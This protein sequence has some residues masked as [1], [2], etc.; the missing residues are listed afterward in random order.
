MNYVKPKIFDITKRRPAVLLVGNGL[1]R[2]MGDDTTWDN[3]I[4]KLA[5]D[6]AIL[7]KIKRLDYSIRAT[8]TADEDDSKR[9]QRYVK[10]FDN[11]FK[12]FDN[13]LL[14]N[15]LR[16][17][18]DAVLTTNYTYELENALDENFPRSD[19]KEDWACT[20]AANFNTRKQPDSVRLLNTFNRLKNEDGKDVD[21]WHIHGEVRDPASMILTH[22]EYGRLVTE[23]VREEENENNEGE[24][25]FNS[26]QDYFVYGD[27]YILGQGVNFAEFDLW[28]M[29]SRRRREKTGHGRTI[30]YAPQQFNKRFTDVEEALDQIGVKIDNCGVTLPEWGTK[31]QNEMNQIFRNF[32]NTASDRIRNKI[33]NPLPSDTELLIE[34]REK[35]AKNWTK[36][37]CIRMM[38]QLAKTKVFTPGDIDENELFVPWLYGYEGEDLSILALFTTEDAFPDGKENLIELTGLE[39]LELAEEIPEIKSINIDLFSPFGNVWLSVKQAEYMRKN[40]EELIKYVE[41]ADERELQ[42]RRNN[43]LKASEATHYV[44]SYI[45]N[46]SFDNSLDEL[47]FDIQHSGYFNY[48]ALYHEEEVQWTAPKWAKP[49]DIAFF[50]HT[51]T[52]KSIITRLRTELK[53]QKDTMPTEKYTILDREINRALQNYEKIGGKIFAIGQVCAPTEEIDEDDPF[54]SNDENSKHWLSRSYACVSNIFLLKHPV[55][56]DDF[57]DFIMLARGGSYSVV[58]GE[59]FSRLRDLIMEK[60]QD[61]E[62]FPYY[63]RKSVAAPLALSDITDNNWMQINSEMRS[64][65][66]GKTQFQSFYTN[67]LLRSIGDTKKYWQRCRFSKPEMANDAIMDSVIV[68]NKKYLP[69]RI[70]FNPSD[71]GTPAEIAGKYCNAAEIFI[72]KDEKIDISRIY[73]DRVMVIDRENISIYDA[74]SEDLHVLMQLDDLKS[75]EDVAVLKQKLKSALGLSGTP[76]DSNETTSRTEPDMQLDSV[77]EPADTVEPTL[78]VAP[79]DDDETTPEN[80]DASQVSDYQGTLYTSAE[81]PTTSLGWQEY[82]L[83]AN[84]GEI[85]K[86]AHLIVQG[87]KVIE[88]EK[89]IEKLRLSF[90]VR[91]SE[92][93]TDA[94]EKAI[95]AAK[96]QISKIKGVVYCWAAE[97]DPKTYTGFRYHEDVK[98]RDDELPLT[99]IRN[100]VV[101]TLL[102][103]GPLGEDDLLVQTCRTFGYQRLGPNL[104]KRLSEGIDF[105][106]AD[107]KI[108]LNKQKQYELREW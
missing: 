8:V 11:D 7:D 33:E 21:I 35:M 104:R 43:A 63:F 90:G 42:R 22:E 97:I 37:N 19:H 95:K 48:E 68:F 84:K 17:P 93:V 75:V 71:K 62:D 72:G 9:W 107:R 86:R 89:L 85:M 70:L 10:L 3:A 57:T 23:L 52:A 34:Y 46:C 55:S 5:K 67:Y 13:P 60:N 14:K 25:F 32:Y 64:E 51:R 49:G 36:A 101:R 66:S 20:T 53:A 92:I 6:D 31:P 4:L 30:Y 82:C 94:T 78:E 18:F 24:I 56:M 54:Y 29:L 79:Q 102:D 2:C 44:Q 38:Y 96:I 45:S 41:E 99:E 61:Q 100:A 27:L 91:N 28:W 65:F 69:V 76:A 16:V 80:P 40:P 39:A 83:P 105:A 106:V 50:I 47:W 87:E 26:W 59:N 98:R 1:N 58:L 77:E 108:K 103:N 88:K 15:L 73:S 74:S 81:Y 12:Y